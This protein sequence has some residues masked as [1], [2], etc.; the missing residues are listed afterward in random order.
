MG[1][2][3]YSVNSKLRPFEMFS[4]FVVS[5][6]VLPLLLRCTKAKLEWWKDQNITNSLS[7][8]FGLSNLAL[9]TIPILRQQK[10]WVGG[11]KKWLLVLVI[12]GQFFQSSWKIWEKIFFRGMAVGMIIEKLKKFGVHRCIPQSTWLWQSISP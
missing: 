8:R 6:N 5:S 12:R 4:F 11:V 3:M 2:F 10:D 1:S 7:C 9:G